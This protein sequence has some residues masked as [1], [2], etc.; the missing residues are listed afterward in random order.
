MKYRPSIEQ[1]L[2][3][4]NQRG[5]RS[6]FLLAR[7]QWPSSTSCSS[8]S[9]PKPAAPASRPCRSTD[10][11]GGPFHTVDLDHLTELKI[12]RNNIEDHEVLARRIL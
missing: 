2:S 11:P 4:E 3:V 1:F 8:A 7:R 12:F 5:D 10:R 6:V 9:A